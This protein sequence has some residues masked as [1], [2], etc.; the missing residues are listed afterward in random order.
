MESI[1]FRNGQKR[2]LGG[3]PIT[4][5]RMDM[6]YEPKSSLRILEAKAEDSGVYQCIVGYGD[7]VY[8]SAEMVVI[9][10]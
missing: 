2:V 6:G 10:K 3:T 1:I 9:G 5:K 7:D 8:G 4:K